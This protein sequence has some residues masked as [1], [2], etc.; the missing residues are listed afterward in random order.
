MTPHLARVTLAGFVLL[1]AG[2]TANALYRQGPVDRPARKPSAEPVR[3]EAQRQSAVPSATSK[4]AKK[5]KTAERTAPEPAAAP[6]KAAQQGGQGLKVRMVRVATV[7]EAP[8]EEVDADTVREVQAELSKRGFGPLVA[9]GAMSPATR[10]AIMAFEQEHRLPLTG[11]A[12]QELLKLIVFGTPPAAG[13]SG[14]PEV[15]SPQAQAVIREVQQLLADQ[16]YRPGASDGRLSAETVAAIR[17]FEADQGLV[18]KG[19]IS[20]AL[21]ERLQSGMAAGGRHPAQ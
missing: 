18:P 2:V 6:V 1:A 3:S 15:R 13:A 19:L 4:T 12:S 21:L 17:T 11:E 8:A 14:L 20:V 7:G 5:D 10:A 9:D 16:G